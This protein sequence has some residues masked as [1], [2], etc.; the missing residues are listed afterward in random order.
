MYSEILQGY[1][2]LFKSPQWIIL[3]AAAVMFYLK[4]LQEASLRKLVLGESENNPLV[5]TFY[6]VFYGLAGG[7][8]ISLL[9]GMFQIAFFTY[10]EVAIIFMLSIFS[11]TRF[12]SYVNIGFHALSV[13]LLMY[14]IQGKLISA[15]DLIQIFLFLGISM[16]VQGV[17]F[18]VSLESGSLPVLF[19]RNDEI[20]GGFRFEKSFMLPSVAAFFAAGGSILGSPLL[21]LPVLQFFSVKETVMTF[22]KE[23]GRRILSAL[24]ILFGVLIFLL[25]YFTSFHMVWTYVLLILV[26]L[27]LYLEPLVFRFLERR[28]APLFVSSEEEILVLEVR[29]SSAAFNA[30]LRSGDRIFEVDGKEKP[31]YKNLLA[32][33][34][35]LSYERTIELKVHRKK[36]EEQK[37]LFTILPGT[38]TGILVVPPSAEFF[39]MKQ[40]G[41]G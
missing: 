5:L 4:N 17:V 8:L 34:G 23:E 21:F 36:S 31:T 41:N 11:V 30:G 37:I 32:F 26:P 38:S 2:N 25:A 24:K 29:E 10:L 28:R 9:A 27:L 39:R 18:L 6:Q 14:L 3:M 1:F 20:R 22:G 40:E 13:F 16:M 19:S 15:H 12:S 35:T 7:F 33:M